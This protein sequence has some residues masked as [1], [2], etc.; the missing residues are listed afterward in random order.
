MPRFSIAAA[1]LCFALL[2][3][4][5]L[6]Q[7]GAGQGGRHQNFDRLLK[8]LDKNGDGKISR[9]EWTRNPKAFDRMDANKDGLVTRDEAEAAFKQRAERREKS[10]QAFA[11]MDKDH[12]GKISRSEWTGKPKAFDRLDLNH[13]GVISHEELKARRHKSANRQGSTTPPAPA[14]PAKP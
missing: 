6:A 14:S 12:D 13:D 7:T 4:W 2:S 5:A 10:E 9:D 1:G 3:G 11:A 8:R